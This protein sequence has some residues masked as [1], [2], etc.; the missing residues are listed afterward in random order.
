MGY[1][2]WYDMRAREKERERFHRSE[3]EELSTER[4]QNRAILTLRYRISSQLVDR[5]TNVGTPYYLSMSTLEVALR[6]IATVVTHVA[7]MRGRERTPDAE[8]CAWALGVPRPASPFA[9]RFGRRSSRAVPPGPFRAA[10][11]TR[12]AGEVTGVS[13]RCSDLNWSE[14]GLGGL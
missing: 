1:Q 13:H 14:S 12:R 9:P 11:R 4:T 6:C 10:R 3:E 5:P 7:F 2:R 8:V